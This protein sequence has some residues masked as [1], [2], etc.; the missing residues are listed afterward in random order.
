MTRPP[1]RPWIALA[2][3]RP[4]S[5]LRL[6][7]LPFAGGGA[8]VF[9]GWVDTFP[10]GV[11]VLPVQLPGRESRFGEPPYLSLDRLLPDLMAAL[12]PLLDRPFAFFGYSLGALIAYELTHLLKDTRG[13]EPARLLVAAHRAPDLPRLSVEL[14]RLPSDQFWDWIG[15]YNGTSHAVM[16]EPEMRQILEPILRADFSIA[17]TYRHQPRPPLSCPVSAF[18]GERDS[19]IPP[20][21][22]A[23]WKR[24]S[25]G[26]FDLSLIDGDHF[27]LFRHAE[28]LRRMVVQRLTADLA[29]SA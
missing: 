12:E 8:S 19:V 3:P 9:R 11:D 7:C 14:H 6:F 22:I 29:V 18:G 16:N 4:D 27:F 24:L 15:Q 13:I 20:D 25:R 17:E 23:A 10:D 28:A 21:Q 1:L 5:R 2:Q 26:R